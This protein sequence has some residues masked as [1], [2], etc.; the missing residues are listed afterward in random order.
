MSWQAVGVDLGGTKVEAGLVKDGQVE[1]SVRAAVPQAGP[2]AILET[3][4]EAVRRVHRPGLPVGVGVAGQVGAGGVV[5]GAPNLPF[6]ELPL[7]RTLGRALGSEPVVENDARAAAF[8]QFQLLHPRPE[9]L[10][11]ITVGTGVGS[12]V[13]AE[14]RPLRGTNGLAGEG[15]HLVAVQD[16][17]PC[18]CGRRGCVEAY[19]GGHSLVRRYRALAGASG[20][21]VTTAAQILKLARSGERLAVRVWEDGVGALRVLL[22]ALVLLFDPD[23]VALGGGVAAAAPELRDALRLYLEREAA[24]EQATPPAMV[25]LQPGA[26]VVGAA[27]LAWL[28]E[29]DRE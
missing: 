22:R 2:D 16:G 24:W 1:A 17:E 9:L 6:R 5:L 28:A 11:V 14:G 26:A 3:V 19:A 25:E 27:R 7:A 4:V 10:T 12:A 20:S 29:R 21:Q 18:A 8:G 13:V 15:G 23:V